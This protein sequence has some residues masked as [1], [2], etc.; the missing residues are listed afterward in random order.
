MKRSWMKAGTA[1]FEEK[2]KTQAVKMKKLRRLV[3]P[4]RLVGGLGNMVAIM[5]PMKVRTR[6][7]ERKSSGVRRM[8]LKLRRMS[9]H[10]SGRKELANFGP[11]S[12]EQASSTPGVKQSFSFTVQSLLWGVGVLGRISLELA[13]GD[14]LWRDYYMSNVIIHKFC[15]N[16]TSLE[17]Q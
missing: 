9:I 16:K 17:Q 11:W 1:S 7:R 6:R 15:S 13:Q 4:W 2:K 10:V 8:F 3:M 5:K 14:E 12:T